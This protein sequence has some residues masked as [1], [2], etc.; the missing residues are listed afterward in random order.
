LLCRHHG[1]ELEIPLYRSYGFFNR[2][3]SVFDCGGMAFSEVNLT[4]GRSRLFQP[5]W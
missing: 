2:N 4:A 5:A 3:Y 1:C